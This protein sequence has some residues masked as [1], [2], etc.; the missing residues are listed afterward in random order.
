MRSRPIAFVGGRVWTAGY[1]GSRLLDVLL[2]DRDIF[3]G[4][5][6][7]HQAS[8]TEVWIAGQREYL[9]AETS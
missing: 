4:D 6:A 8:V 3:E 5:D 7:L 1:S 9:R 2:I